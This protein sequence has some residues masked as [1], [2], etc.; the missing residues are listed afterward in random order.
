MHFHVRPAPSCKDVCLQRVGR[1][2]HHG[3][4]GLTD[5]WS[6]WPGRPGGAHWR[7]FWSRSLS[8]GDPPGRNHPGLLLGRPRLR[9]SRHRRHLPGRGLERCL[10]SVLPDGL[11]DRFCMR[12]MPWRGIDYQRIAPRHML[13]EASDLRQHV[14]VGVELACE[15]GQALLGVAVDAIP[16]WWR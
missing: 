12:G 9:T 15:Q 4:Q 2:R 6:R 3:A 7:G 13:C 5:H 11:G 16:I 1:R 10:R 8:R 14:L